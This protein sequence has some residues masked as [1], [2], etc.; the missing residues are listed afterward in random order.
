MIEGQGNLIVFSGQAIKSR[1]TINYKYTHSHKQRQQSSSS[2]SCFFE[3]RPQNICKLQAGIKTKL[4][5]L[6]T[7]MENYKWR[8]G[9]IRRL[10]KKIERELTC[11]TSLILAVDHSPVRVSWVTSLRDG[12]Y[13]TMKLPSWKAS[14]SAVGSMTRFL[15]KQDWE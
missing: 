11:S 4:H 13:V 2:I 15:P 7:N 8:Y 10:K 12:M 14:S 5:C 9:G 1:L 3:T 6:P